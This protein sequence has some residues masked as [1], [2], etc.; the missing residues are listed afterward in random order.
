MHELLD[1]LE[2]VGAVRDEMTSQPLRA[3]LIIESALRAQ[4]VRN[5]AAFI[6]ARWRAARE[7]RPAA[8]APELELERVPPDL[9]ALEYVWS[10]PPSVVGGL[11]LKLLS[12][13]IE[14][15]GGY[16]ALRASFDRHR[17]G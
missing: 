8:P 11:I 7:R 9:D 3:L 17:S 5:P 14:K 15:H 6:I 12:V 10:R 4:G 13:A 2:I 1:E 16:G